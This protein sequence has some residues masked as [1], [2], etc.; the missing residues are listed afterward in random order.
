MR[1]P[2]LLRILTPAGW[3]VLVLALVAV[4]GVAGRGL[5]LSWDP[6]DL[7]GR[8]LRAAEARASAAA[9]E[10]GARRLET[11][12]MVDQARRL[13]HAHQQTVAVE[14]VTA[15]AAA[16]ARNAHDA[17]HPLDPARADRLRRHDRELC[18]LSP[19]VCGPA[20]ADPAAGGGQAVPAGPA[21]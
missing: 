4:A 16:Q 2:A 10:A 17:S 11:E 14:R 20:K 12:A 7:S 3:T 8:R 6:L 15:V 13:D 21:G 1:T 18:R 5:G 19:A 9:A